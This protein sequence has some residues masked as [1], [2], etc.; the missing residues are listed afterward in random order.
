MLAQQ[1]V[2]FD[3]LLKQEQELCV[4]LNSEEERLG[5]ELLASEYEASIHTV[6]YSR[7]C[8]CHILK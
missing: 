2:L 6:L 8:Q 5:G 7:D 1:A 4:L 3:T